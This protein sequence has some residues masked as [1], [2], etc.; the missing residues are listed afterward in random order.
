VRDDDLARL[1]A[2]VRSA[3][4]VR[5]SPDLVGSEESSAVTLL[6]RERRNSMTSAPAP[7]HLRPTRIGHR[8]AWAFAAAF[9]AILV[10]IGALTL[11]LRGGDDVPFVDQPSN[12]NTQ[13][14]VQMGPITWARADFEEGSLTLTTPVPLGSGFIW[15]QHGFD[16]AGDPITEIVVSSDGVTWS[17]VATEAL[18][19]GEAVVWRGGG[20]WGA[21]GE[22]LTEADHLGLLITHNGSSFS[23]S[24]PRSTLETSADRYVFKDLAVGENR[25]VAVYADPALDPEQGEVLLTSSDGATWHVVAKPEGAI[26]VS[27]VVSTPSGIFLSAEADSE[28]RPNPGVLTW[29]LTDDLAWDGVPITDEFLTE[30]RGPFGWGGGDI[31]VGGTWDQASETG[32][33]GIWYSNDTRTWSAVDMASFEGLSVLSFAGTDRGILAFA[34]DVDGRSSLVFSS[35]AVAWQR[36]SAADVF[37]AG[38]EDLGAFNAS[39]NGSRIIVPATGP[40]G[41]ELWVGVVEETAVQRA[42]GDSAPTATQLPPATVATTEATG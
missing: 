39:S 30:V 34:H 6:L 7:E 29:I 33:S 40:D 18:L 12:P 41:V 37:G 36:W 13:E 15:T 17:P 26:V 14:T 2:A 9:V 24:D 32:T 20:P 21:A 5:R 1:E 38:V 35:D 28:Q 19:D 31:V 27:D 3:N 22:I 25:V 16:D 11:L 42:P 23:R 4:P 10:G 8:R